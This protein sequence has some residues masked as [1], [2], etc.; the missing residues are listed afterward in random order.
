MASTVTLSG[1][2]F[3][4]TA[5][6]L[7]KEAELSVRHAVSERGGVLVRMAFDGAIRVNT[8]RFI[9]SVTIIDS[10]RTFSSPGG[11]RVYSMSIDVPARTDVVTTSNATYGPW[12]EGVGSRNATTRF[13]GYR[14]FRQ[15]GQE[16]GTQA[17]RIAEDA[18]APYVRRMG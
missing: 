1:P 17:T 5:D 11:R 14:G 2:W 8:G 12:L 9:A 4:G 16:L 3:D 13:R 15:A 10:S 6:R 7:M 18:L